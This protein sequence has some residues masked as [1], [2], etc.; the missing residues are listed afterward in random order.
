[1]PTRVR[2][3][4]AI[5]QEIQVNFDEA[6]PGHRYKLYYDGWWTKEVDDRKIAVEERQLESA[7]DRQRQNTQARINALRQHQVG[8][9]NYTELD[10]DA[11]HEALR[12]IAEKSWELGS[13]TQGFAGLARDLADRQK[14]LAPLFAKASVAG[15]L[16]VEARSVSPVVVGTG[17]EHP[18]ENGFLFYDPFGLPFLPGSAVKGVVRRAAEELALQ[19]EP[20]LPLGLVWY[21]FG[22][23]ATSGMIWDSLKRPQSEGRAEWRKLARDA[24]EKNRDRARAS[25][26]WLEELP[27]VQNLRD[28]KND[29]RDLLKIVL[30]EILDP[31]EQGPGEGRKPLARALHFQGALR[32][33]DVFFVPPRMRVEVMTPHYGPYYGTGDAGAQG[34]TPH[35]TSGPQP[36]FFLAVDV[37]VKA[38]FHVVFQPPKVPH[39]PNCEH[40]QEAVRRAL[41]HAWTMVGFGA[42]TSVGYGRFRLE[43]APAQPQGPSEI[44]DMATLTYEPGCARLIARFA[45]TNKQGQKLPEAILEG[46]DAVEKVLQ[47]L[48]E[49]RK[50]LLE[51]RKSAQGLV[52]ARVDGNRSIIVKIE[53]A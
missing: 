8:T 47:G 42:K 39:A 52:T 11:K 2:G 30:D 17:V 9:A 40:W 37:G 6:P 13:R 51:K 1:M 5:P 43:G 27:G 41:T 18:N 35:E 22:F 15:V 53:E 44:R 26:T 24:I 14:Q 45:A 28:E 25:L 50:K 23:D 36:H 21:L 29:T 4:A 3:S 10:N 16:S 46:K 48:P 12:A 20:L 34:T 32:F 31:K 49:L 33:M 7:R 19:Q 38:T